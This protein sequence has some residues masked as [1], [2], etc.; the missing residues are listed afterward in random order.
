[1]LLAAWLVVVSTAVGSAGTRITPQNAAQYQ[2]KDLP[3]PVTIEES[4]VRLDCGGK[5]ILNPCGLHSGVGIEVV[6]KVGSYVKNV[7]IINCVVEGFGIG[8][9]IERSSTVTLRGGNRIQ[10]NLTGLWLDYNEGTIYIHGNHINNNVHAAVAM[11]KCKNVGLYQNDFFNNAVQN[12]NKAL[13]VYQSGLN[14]SYL[15]QNNWMPLPNTR[16]WD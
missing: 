15:D 7:Q 6:G 4:N 10:D 13:E 2:G 1:M 12:D 11:W 9:N 5:R 8:I 3:A 16:H 14:P